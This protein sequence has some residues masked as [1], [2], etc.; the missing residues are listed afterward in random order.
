M[1]ALQLQC[2]LW[3][4]SDLLAY[5]MHARRGLAVTGT[6]GKTTT[7]ALLAA[8]LVKA[9]LEPS[10]AIGGVVPEFQSNAAFGRGE[11]FIAEADESDGTFLKYFPQ[12]AIVTNIDLDHMNHY[13]TED[14]LIASFQQAMSQVADKSHLLWCGDDL[15]LR[16]LEPEGISYGFSPACDLII[17]GFQQSAWHVSFDMAF[18][19]DIYEG[20]TVNLSGRH[21]AL[22][23]AA[24]FGLALTLGIS[25][26]HI[27]AALHAF[28]GVKRRCERK[29][30]VQGV[31]FLD[32]YA[33]HP[34]EIQ[35]TLQAIRQAVK[36]RRLIAVH[37]PHR[38]TRTRDCL[39]LYGS[40]FAAADMLFL[41]DIYGAGEAP[42]AGISSDLLLQEVAEQGSLASC[43]CTRHQLAKKIAEY[44][45]PGDVV[46][47]LGAGDITKLA[48][49][50]MPLCDPSYSYA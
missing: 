46:V 23:A 28:S 6:H 44:V 39:G 50:L 25:E 48:Q 37:Q 16:Q 45:Q 24:V 30:E 29:G 9:G 40:I 41:T 26:G 32:D 35:T 49:E 18:R 20:I 15:R 47:S 17:S 33:H 19:G 12:G 14:K 3:H 10:Y 31:L 27:R 21:N 22:N 34:T 43:Y 13:E 36:G 42:I 4:R 2:P 38:Y 11:F 7:T 1:A 8:V 5:L